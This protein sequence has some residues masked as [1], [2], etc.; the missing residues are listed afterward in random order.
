MSEDQC[1]TKTKSYGPPCFVDGDGRPICEYQVTECGM[2]LVDI[3]RNKETE[4]LFQ[5]AA[6][7][8]HAEILSQEDIVVHVKA[9][10]GASLLLPAMQ[11]QLDKI[12]ARFKSD[13]EAFLK[14]LRR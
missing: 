7:T 10:V 8:G 2:S 1:I 9:E 14:K 12:V 3:P 6:K 4:R 13:A 11:A 5:A